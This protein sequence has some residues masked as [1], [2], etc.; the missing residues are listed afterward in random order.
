MRK[1]LTLHETGHEKVDLTVSTRLGTPDFVGPCLV[2]EQ[3]GKEIEVSEADARRLVKT[4]NQFI[5]RDL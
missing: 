3:N 1:I 4:L 5:L 2:L